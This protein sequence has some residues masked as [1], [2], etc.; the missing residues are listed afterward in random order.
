MRVGGAREADALIAAN[1]AFGEDAEPIDLV[2][3]RERFT[4]VPL[5][6]RGASR[7]DRIQD[8][9]EAKGAA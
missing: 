7:F 8:E 4:L 3:M 5:S 2:D 6:A 1:Q 9:Y